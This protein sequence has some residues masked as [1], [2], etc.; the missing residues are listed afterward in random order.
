MFDTLRGGRLSVWLLLFLLLFVV[1]VWVTLTGGSKWL[2]HTGHNVLAHF[3]TPL[4]T[5][6]MIF[7][8]TLGNGSVVVTVAAVLLVVALIRRCYAEALAI[9]L[10]LLMGNLLSE[11]LKE[12]FARP[13]PS[14]VNLISL[15]ESYSFPSGHAM[16][17]SSFYLF[18]VYL[19]DRRY[20]NRFLTSV[21]LLTVGLTVLFICVSRIYLG[22]HYTS[23]VLAG[24][25]GGAVW[26][27]VVI[28]LYEYVLCRFFSRT[29]KTLPKTPP[30]FP[31]HRE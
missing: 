28:A 23:D 4:L 7:F 10:C 24:M 27:L 18:L 25:S 9:V 12:W 16:V 20:R 21:L 11:Q 19:I 8:T 17:S 3:H 5:E 14:G 15:P 30:V 31:P 1:S 6:L 2:D 26:L 29:R 13:R 22:V